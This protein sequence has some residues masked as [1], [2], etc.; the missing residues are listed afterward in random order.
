MNKSWIT[1]DKE[2]VLMNKMIPTLYMLDNE[3]YI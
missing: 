2:K 3:C 1:Y